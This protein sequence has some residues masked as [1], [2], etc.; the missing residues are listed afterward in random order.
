LQVFVIGI[1][2]NIDEDQLKAISSPPHE[3]GKTYV[4]T[5]DYTTLSQV[6]NRL[7]TATCSAEKPDLRGT[8]AISPTNKQMCGQM[9]AETSRNIAA[10]M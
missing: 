6:L 7:I 8:L 10:Y 5:P 4:T 2:S 9:T 3:R 1:T